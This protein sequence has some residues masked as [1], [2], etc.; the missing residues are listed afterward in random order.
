MPLV[1]EMVEIVGVRKDGKPKIKT[2]K[3]YWAVCDVCG[4]GTYVVST[5]LTKRKGDPDPTPQRACRMT[6]RCTGRHRRPNL[7]QEEKSR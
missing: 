4:E 3:H 1:T 7:K 2:T 6:P 5:G